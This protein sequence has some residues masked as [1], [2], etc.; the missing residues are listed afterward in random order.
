MHFSGITNN[1]E[2]L[3][4]YSEMVAICLAALELL[5]ETIF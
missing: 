4:W 5:V 1:N 3:N 2:I